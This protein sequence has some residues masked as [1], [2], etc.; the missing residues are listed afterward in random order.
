MLKSCNAAKFDM[1]C[2]LEGYMCQ[3][4]YGVLATSFCAKLIRRL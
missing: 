4:E 3:E 2:S 1:I